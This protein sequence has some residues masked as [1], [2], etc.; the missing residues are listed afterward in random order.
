MGTVQLNFIWAHDSLG[1]VFISSTKLFAKSEHPF[2]YIK[3]DHLREW[4][5]V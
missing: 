5:Q 4:K 1:K 3:N 2:F